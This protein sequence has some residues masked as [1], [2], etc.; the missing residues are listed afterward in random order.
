MPRMLSVV[1]PA[2][3]EADSIEATV[4]EIVQGAPDPTMLELVLVDD[5]SS[6]DTASAMRRAKATTPCKI[7][8]VLREQQGGLGGAL[9]SGFGAATGE[10]V[11]WIPGDGEYRMHDI[12]AGLPILDNAQIVL[13][14]RTSRGQLHRGLVSAAMHSL[15]RV[16]FR[17]DLRDFCGIFLMRRDDWIALSI[18]SASAFFALDVAI[19]ADRMG[20]TS[21]WVTAPWIP[22]QAGRSSVFKPSVLVA[23]LGELLRLKQAQ[24]RR[25]RTGND[26]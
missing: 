8:L 25:A 3:N 4:E 13:V 24:H 17:M 2:H 12:A 19:T 18:D 26:A 20:Y 11:T 5:A 6:D 22:R 15:I 16:L 9:L 7:T 23:S 21:A 10:I 1:V 14:R